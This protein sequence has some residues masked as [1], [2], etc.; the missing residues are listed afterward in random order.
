MSLRFTAFIL[1]PSLMEDSLKLHLLLFRSSSTVF[2]LKIAHSSH[3]SSGDGRHVIW[4]RVYLEDVL[5]VNDSQKCLRSLLRRLMTIA[6]NLD[7]SLPTRAK[8]L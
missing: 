4:L 7:R 3:S 5:R 2:D 1:V 8:N 6:M